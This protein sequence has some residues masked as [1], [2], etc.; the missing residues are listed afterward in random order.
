MKDVRV[1]MSNVFL[2]EPNVQSSSLEAKTKGYFEGNQFCL[3]LT[4]PHL[5]QAIRAFSVVQQIRYGKNI[6][7]MLVLEVRCCA[8]LANDLDVTFKTPDC[9]TVVSM[10][11]NKDGSPKKDSF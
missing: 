10:G 6:W 2:P 9:F 5:C 11:P 4:W 7:Q 3:I 1:N 8:K